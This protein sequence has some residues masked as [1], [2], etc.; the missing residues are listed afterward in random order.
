MSFK[1]EA[2]E[3]CGVIGPNGAGKT[4]LFNAISRLVPVRSGDIKVGGRS[5]AATKP[6]DV[7]RLGIAR[8]FQLV[9]IFPS[10]T[11]EDNIAV[12]ALAQHKI[13]VIPEILRMKAAAGPRAR[14]VQ[15]TREIAE[16]CGL[17]G[18]SNRLAGTLPLGMQ[19]RTELARA[20]ATAPE[21]LLLDE[22]ASGLS[23]REI[24]EFLDLLVN[25][26]KSLGLTIIMIEHHLGLVMRA[27]DHIIVLNFGRKI[28]EGTAA[29][30]RKHPEVVSAYI[31]AGA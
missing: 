30:V 23:H 13:P 16:L 28:A 21:I 29:E 9:G 15:R 4:T 18:H 11:V 14:L 8:T 10:L 25:I 5:L 31:G 24:D 2:G 19:K 26:K 12:G 6:S 1:L 17:G 20:L 27:S 3:F 22:P 7:V